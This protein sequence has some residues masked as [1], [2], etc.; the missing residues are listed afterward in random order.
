MKF[1]DYYKLLIIIVIFY[2]VENE[3]GTL[4]VSLVTDLA[5]TEWITRKLF[6]SNHIT[7]GSLFYLEFEFSAVWYGQVTNLF[8]SQLPHL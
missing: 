3:F 1:I 7:R 2:I 8:V 6:S 4:S 5:N